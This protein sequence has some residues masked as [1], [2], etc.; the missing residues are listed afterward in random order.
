MEITNPP[1]GIMIIKPT[2]NGSAGTATCQAQWESTLAL[3]EL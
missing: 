1:Y 2:A 3:L